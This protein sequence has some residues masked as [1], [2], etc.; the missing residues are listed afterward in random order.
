M[1]W[2]TPQAWNEGDSDG[3]LTSGILIYLVPF[4]TMHFLCV[5]TSLQYGEGGGGVGGTVAYAY[6]G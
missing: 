5:H 2:L 1:A 6:V 4:D 3:P